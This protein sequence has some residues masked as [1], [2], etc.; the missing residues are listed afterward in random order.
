M[1]RNQGWRGLE[2]APLETVMTESLETQLRSRQRTVRFLTLEVAEQCL[3]FVHLGVNSGT[4]YLRRC[5]ESWCW[6]ELAVVEGEDS[7]QV[8]VET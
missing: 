2:L 8:P 1:L 7:S 4:N 5:L 6:S 3:E